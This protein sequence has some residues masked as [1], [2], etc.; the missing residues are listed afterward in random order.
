MAREIVTLILNARKDIHAA[1]TI[2]RCS[3]ITITNMMTAAGLMVLLGFRLLIRKNI[4][5]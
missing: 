1:K 2:A 5:Q 4:L 3:E